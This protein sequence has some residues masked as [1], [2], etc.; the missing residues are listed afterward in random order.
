MNK[1][2]IGTLPLGLTYFEIG[3]NILIKN[4]LFLYKVFE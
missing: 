4:D 2:P 3:G 1:V